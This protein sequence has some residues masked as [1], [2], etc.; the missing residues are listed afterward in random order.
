M[1]AGGSA[2]ELILY[3]KITCKYNLTST[4]SPEVL[5]LLLLLVSGRP[6]LRLGL[7][8]EGRGAD[9]KV[10]RRD[11]CT[12][13]HERLQPHRIRQRKQVRLRRLWRQLAT[14]DACSEATLNVG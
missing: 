3:T 7:G 5:V 14:P 2:R 1:H 4:L 12:L 11:G 8:V 13:R 10:I 9:T 6:R